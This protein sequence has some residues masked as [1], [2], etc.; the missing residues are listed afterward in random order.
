MIRFLVGLT[1]VACCV[2]AP[3]QERPPAAAGQVTFLY[4]KDLAKANEF[5]GEVLGLEIEFDLEWVKIY[6]V[7]PTSSVGLVNATEG[8]L[9]PSSDKPVMVSMVVERDQVDAWWT[10]L[11]SKGVDVGEA[12]GPEGDGAVRAFGFEDPEGYS[13]EVFAWVDK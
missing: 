10:Y 8:S 13:L 3:A 2:A 1:L 9:R 7:S 11:K 12:P 6:K 5:Y 4:F